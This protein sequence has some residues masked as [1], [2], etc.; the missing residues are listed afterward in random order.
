[1]PAQWRVRGAE[2][3]ARRRGAEQLS[4]F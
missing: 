4:L 3:M 2:A 1:M